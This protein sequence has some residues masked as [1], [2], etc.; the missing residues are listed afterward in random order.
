MPGAAPLVDLEWWRDA[1]GYALLDP[2]PPSPEPPAMFTGL[3]PSVG[4]PARIVRKGGEL[5][6]YRPLL[7]YGGIPLLKNFTREISPQGMLEF[8]EKFG[9]LTRSG[10]DPDSGDGIPM[11]LKSA[12]NMRGLLHAV[13][14]Y[15]ADRVQHLF[16][17]ELT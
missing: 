6:L 4:R 5:E 11:L 2:M 14:R 12:E 9:P 1:N 13:S 8:V 7:L 10:L 17:E 15:G 3:S 16:T